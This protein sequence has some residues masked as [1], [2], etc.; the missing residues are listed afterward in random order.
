MLR[1]PAC[2]TSRRVVA[3]LAL[4]FALALVSWGH[5]GLIA[6]HV[7]GGQA[8][9][10]D[11]GGS[12]GMDFDVLAPI[13]ITQLGVFDDGSAGLNLP[14]T[15]H[16]YDRTATA[17]PLA[18]VSFATS[19]GAT[20]IGGSRFQPLAG[21]LVL[22]AGFQG[23][24]V[25]EGYGST[26]RNGNCHGATPAWST[27]SGSGRIAFVG[28]GRFGTAGAYPG[29]ADGGPANRYAAGTFMFEPHVPGQRFIDVPNYSFEELAHGDGGWGNT[30]PGWTPVGGNNAGNYN[31]LPGEY[32]DPIPSAQQVA[33]INSAT[34]DS[35]PLSETL[36]ARTLYTLKVDAGPRPTG[37]SDYFVELRAGG[38][39][40]GR[41]DTVAGNLP[42]P[43]V[44]EF[45]TGE[46]TFLAPST[47]PAGQPLEIHLGK[48]GGGQA[49]FDNVRLTA[50]DNVPQTIAHKVPAGTLGNQA[51]GGSLGMDFDVVEPIVVSE[52]GVFDDG[53]NGLNRT[54][55]AH[56]YDRTT[57]Q[58]P[59]VSLTFPT[60]TGDTL[61]GG[62][63]FQAL[64]SELVLPAGFQGTIVAEG[65]GGGEQNGNSGS[66]IWTM[67]GGGRIAFVG[68]S[69]FGAA[70]AFPATPDGGPANR[71]A[72][73]TFAFDRT[74]VGETPVAVPNFSFELNPHGEGGYSNTVPGWTPSGG[75]NA[76]NYNPPAGTFSDPVPSGQQIA[77]IS[78]GGLT[79]DPLPQG[80]APG[81][82]YILEADVGRRS[83]Y[84]T[85]APS[86]SMAL[87]AGGT[88]LGWANNGNIFNIQTPGP[89][90]FGP[91]TLY[92]TANH[93]AALGTPLDIVLSGGGA[94][95]AAFDNLR[96]TVISGRAMPV[97]NHSF[98]ADDVHPNGGWQEGATGWTASGTGGGI[99][100]LASQIVAA[101]GTQS[102]FIRGGGSLTQLLGMS[103][104][105]GD[106]YILLA[107]VADRWSTPYGGY[108]IE[109]LAGGQTLAIDSSPV[110][111]A[112]QGGFY[113]TP[114]LDYT[115]ADDDPLLNEPL[116]IRLTA[117]GGGTQTYFDNVRFF[118]IV[119]EPTTLALLGL[120]GL[121][122]LRRRRR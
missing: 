49:T 48:I 63:R 23:A 64:P 52:L 51:Y 1:A 88:T 39:L 21:P 38:Q 25:A 17:T 68:S 77:F 71:Y 5:A 36:T 115:V 50:V 96:L 11:Y 20:L 98:E 65:Y 87:R 24:I 111:L 120:G 91:A 2:H 112:I 16:L 79:S 30:M 86:F 72:T 9:N 108:A 78:S 74:P 67:D 117:L 101:D 54:L 61:L 56:I 75:T 73:G 113:L 8:G 76:G 7:R 62:S 122:L 46:L 102:A 58:A 81:T 119:P 15:A 92:A 32:S 105:P 66:P 69:R 18:T 4:A 109:L 82:L 12:L 85:V 60:G 83:V 93:N 57:P 47:V 116:A 100:E 94:A 27:D 121:A 6:Y 55:T 37:P 45:A 40:L 84:T 3:T 95:Q 35:D 10:Q 29:G 103:V 14:I 19:S 89:G 33:F 28:G 53:S 97:V 31:P 59:L 118:A 107:D 99:F 26:E 44:G 34:L 43:P 41:M 114:Y 13:A 90:E 110:A 70:G 104:K 42:A 106:R 22:P 80:L